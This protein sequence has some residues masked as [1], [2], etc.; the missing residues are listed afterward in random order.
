MERAAEILSKRDRAGWPVRQQLDDGEVR[1]EQ[2]TGAEEIARR[3]YQAAFLLAADHA[4]LPQ[5]YQGSVRRNGGD[6]S[7]LQEDSGF[8]ERFP[9]QRI[10]VVPGRGAR[11]RQFYGAQSTGLT[12]SHGARHSKPRSMLRGYF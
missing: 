12:A 5:G 2:S 8:N 10:P 9:G 1:S 6:Q 3:R 11:L 7:E 4:G